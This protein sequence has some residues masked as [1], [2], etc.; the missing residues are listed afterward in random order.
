MDLVM[1]KVALSVLELLANGAVTS[2]TGISCPG[3]N[4]AVLGAVSALSVGHSSCMVHPL[5]T[6]ALM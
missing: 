6:E 2:R 1:E 5:N 3:L 4:W